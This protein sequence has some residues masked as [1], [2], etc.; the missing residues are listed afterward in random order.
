MLTEKFNLKSDDVQVEIDALHSRMLSAR[1]LLNAQRRYLM[2]KIT[3]QQH[4]FGQTTALASGAT[5]EET[6]KALA[7]L[8]EVYSIRKRHLTALLAVLK[9]EAEEE[10]ERAQIKMLGELEKE[11]AA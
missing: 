10:A 1:K 3:C 11:V 6:D 7:S 2:D 8:K 9:D 4:L 5:V